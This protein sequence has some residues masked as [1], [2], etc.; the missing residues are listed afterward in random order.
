MNMR[1]SGF[2]NPVEPGCGYCVLAV[3]WQWITKAVIQTLIFERLKRWIIFCLI[4]MFS[5]ALAKSA[6]FTGLWI[7]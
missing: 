3:F 1:L 5:T 4:A 6:F 2:H 7:T